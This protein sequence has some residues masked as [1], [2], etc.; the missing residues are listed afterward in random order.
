MTTNATN[1]NPKGPAGEGAPQSKRHRSP[2]YPSIPLEKAIERARTFFQHERRNAA[3]VVVAGGHW[4]FKANNSNTLL[5]VAA[6][7]YFGLLTDE[8]TGDKRTVKLTESALRILLDPDE[9]SAVRARLIKEAALKPKIHAEIW[10]K[11]GL[12]LPSD[13]TLKS[14]LLF[15]K[16]F[17]PDSVDGFVAQFKDTILF[18]KLSDSDKNSVNED[19]TGDAGDD[20]MQQPAVHARQ[21]A[22][23]VGVSDSLDFKVIRSPSPGV[24]QKELL[25]FRVSQDCTVQ[26]IFDGLVTQ[27][28]IEKLIRKLELSKDEYPQKVSYQI[29]PYQL[30]GEHEGKWGLTVVRLT[31]DGTSIVEQ[32]FICKLEFES[33]EAAREYGERWIASGQMTS[34]KK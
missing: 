29:E 22:D 34:S 3:P 14:F 23:S 32:P 24:Q 6:L 33:E 11:W 27:A 30:A 12:E 25:N 5:V 13:G 16:K 9:N 17:N 20:L 21:V 1:N 19:A 26:I 31:S 7:K 15:E 10:Q 8:G 18:A 2:A 28:A 4:G